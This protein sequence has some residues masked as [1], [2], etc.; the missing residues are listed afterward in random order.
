MMRSITPTPAGRISSSARLE[1]ETIPILAQW[2]RAR[3]VKLLSAKNSCAK[4]KYIKTRYT[5]L[6]IY[7][8]YIP[9]VTEQAFSICTVGSL[10]L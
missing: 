10:V 2:Y 1:R 7:I 6:V 3:G 5:R 4:Y 8:W 9:M